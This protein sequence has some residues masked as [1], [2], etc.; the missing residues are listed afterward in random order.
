[1]KSLYGTQTGFYTND[2][3]Q[4]GE[5]LNELGGANS[6][7]MIED[8]LVTIN[9]L[10]DKDDRQG[11]KNGARLLNIRSFRNELTPSAQL[12]GKPSLSYN[13]LKVESSNNKGSHNSISEK[14]SKPAI[15]I[16]ITAEDK[17]TSCPQKGTPAIQGQYLNPESPR[18]PLSPAKT[19]SS[20]W[21]IDPDLELRPEQED[22]IKFIS[23]PL[24]QNMNK[25][26][27]FDNNDM[28]RDQ[29]LRIRWKFARIRKSL[30]KFLDR[31][32][33]LEIFKGE[34]SVFSNKKIAFE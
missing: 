17:Q 21:N 33:R 14:H 15:K 1:M 23:P 13:N 25:F 20:T 26:I 28:K 11:Q 29:E 6:Q 2:N 22:N 24:H 30:K 12:S 5:S 34:V 16:T 10:N 7:N 9:N 32:V 27:I 3:K 18:P 31:M 8:G 19:A 4:F